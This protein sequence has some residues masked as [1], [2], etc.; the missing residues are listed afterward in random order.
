MNAP[1]VS[2]ITLHRVKNYGS[3]LQAFATQELLRQ[4]GAQV[5][6]VDYWRP[7]LAD[8]VDDYFDRSRWARYPFMRLPF[9][10]LKSR[11][12]K[13][14]RIV[15]NDF[16]EESFSLSGTRYMSPIELERNPPVADVF[17]V[18]SDQVWNGDYN[19]GGSMPFFLTFAPASARRIS[20]S[21]S[22][23]RSN[24]DDAT[25]ALARAELPKFAAVSVR[26]RSGVEMLAE[27][28]VESTH[29][30]DPVLAVNP[31]F[32]RDFATAPKDNSRRLVVYQLNQS[33]QFD[34][35]VAR[36]EKKLGVQATRI[37]IRG[38]RPSSR[39]RVTQP[40]LRE[41]VSLFRHSEYVITDSF[42]GTA[43][44]LIFNVPFSVVLPGTYGD[45]L[46]SVLEVAGLADR[47]VSD[48]VS[49]DSSAI[50]WSLVNSRLD[51]ARGASREYLDRAVNALRGQR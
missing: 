5:E 22:F 19:V 18:G 33:P 48:G 15:F 7:D 8:G 47:L 24:L 51:A 41:W 25:S 17:C 9:R 14:N 4:T 46:R 32:W 27:M 37:D 12:V 44:S 11:W 39:H 16:I 34:A 28:G 20:F 49:C 29:T 36:A 26:E 35:V 23:G 45:R 43:F 21:S 6:V 40:T 2:L 50:N 38:S 42:H 10:A 3:V 30:L 31:C 1:K 13:R